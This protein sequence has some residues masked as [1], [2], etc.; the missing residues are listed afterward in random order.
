MVEMLVKRKKRPSV[1][2]AIK[3]GHS[4]IIDLKRCMELEGETELERAYY[5]CKV[6]EKQTHYFCSFC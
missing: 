3:P 4:K 1:R 5:V 2:N 6:C